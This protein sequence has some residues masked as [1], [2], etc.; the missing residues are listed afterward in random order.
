MNKLIN[1]CIHVDKH[2]IDVGYTLLDPSKQ[3]ELS[4]S[5]SNL[6]HTLRMLPPKPFEESEK[7][8]LI[9]KLFEELDIIQGATRFLKKQDVK[10][11]YSVLFS[12][13]VKTYLTIIGE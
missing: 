2:L 10:E 6:L 5:F 8:K 1:P 3:Q 13:T 12:K 9:N 4:V 11:S 7:N